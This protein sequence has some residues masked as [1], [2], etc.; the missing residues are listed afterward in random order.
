MKQ[1]KRGFTLIEL[2]IVIAIIG[3]LAGVV[4]VSTGSAREKANRA[5]AL[6]S[7]AS[8]LPEMVTC[9]DDSGGITAPSPST[10]GGV[11]CSAAGH[12]VTWP[13]ISK[14]GWAYSAATD[15]DISDG[16]YTYSITKTGQTN[17]A[18]SLETSG[19]N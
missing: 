15:A 17:V 9:Q 1:V 3:I 10:G 7:A 6:T 4:L 14:T 13:D 18:C 11:I 12:T 2:L 16:V 5:S 19:C 8:V